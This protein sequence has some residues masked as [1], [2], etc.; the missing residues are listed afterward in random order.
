MK[1]SFR[2][3]IVGVFGFLVSFI[4]FTFFWCIFGN[5][6]KSQK[7]L[8]LQVSAIHGNPI[9]SM[10]IDHLCEL[11]A[12]NL[13]NIL[14]TLDFD[15][16]INLSAASP[17]LHSLITDHYMIPK[18][19]IH[20]KLIFINGNIKLSA[21]IIADDDIFIGKIGVVSR[22]LRLYGH[23]ITRLKVD[24]TR[25]LETEMVE[26][27]Q[28]IRE[29]C[30][31]TLLEFQLTESPE[32]VFASQANH[33]ASVR[34]FSIDIRSN[35]P[36]ADVSIR[37]T[38]DHLQTLE[39]GVREYE[40]WAAELIERNGELVTISFPSMTANYAV[41]Y[42]KQMKELSNL[43]EIRVLYRIAADWVQSLQ[44]ILDEFKE[45][46]TI[47]VY[48]I[49]LPRGSINREAIIRVIEAKWGE[50]TM[51]LTNSNYVIPLLS[52][53]RRVQA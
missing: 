24:A 12:Y 32:L 41:E 18:F 44:H 36:L 14:D 7:N 34:H 16:L 3:L 39:I 35:E 53:T 11:D 19:R 52:F 45:L 37:L 29:H 42:L 6:R 20:E 48:F 30:S 8:N 26:F 27:G 47:G 23:I 15:S 51:E 28:L 5:P 22:F 33:F 21:S 38:F 49:D 4:I 9:E 10:Q 40:T 1:A 2:L 43:R 17:S 31:S 50:T 13:M 25:L 46:C